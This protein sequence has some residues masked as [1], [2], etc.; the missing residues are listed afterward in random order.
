[1][2]NPRDFQ[3]ERPASGNRK[4]EIVEEGILAGTN[5]ESIE[6]KPSRPVIADRIDLGG[7]QNATLLVTPRPGPEEMACS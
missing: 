5:G 6:N 2:S 1:M 3:S 7:G 4:F